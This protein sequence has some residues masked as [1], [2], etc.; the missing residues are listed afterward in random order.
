MISASKLNVRITF[1]I[2]LGM[3]ASSICWSIYN[4]YVPIILEQYVPNVTLL[5]VVMAV[6]NMFGVF[7]QPV[8]GIWS[9]RI[10]TRLGRRIPFII[11]GAP[12]AAVLFVVVPYS[13]S[14][15]GLMLT[16]ISFNVMMVTWRAPIVALMP[17]MTPSIHRS[18]ANGIINTMGGIGAVVAFLVGGILYNIGGMPMPFLVAS[19]GMSMC[20]LLMAIFVRERRIREQLGIRDTPVGEK[21]RLEKTQMSRE[22]LRSLVFIILAIF[23]CYFGFNSIETYFTLFA[24]KR[25]DISAGDA[26]MLMTIFPLA[27]FITAVPMG[28]LA[29]RIGRKRVLQLGIAVNFIA[30]I[31]A[32]FVTNMYL[33]GALLVLVGI[34]WGGIVV[35]ALPM[36]VEWGGETRAGLYT[37]IYYLFTGPAGML[38]PI[39]FGIVYDLTKSYDNIFLFCNAAF[40]IAFICL[41]FVRHGE[42]DMGATRNA[43]AGNV[44]PL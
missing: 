30:F 4:A 21:P 38:S 10:N 40:I 31:A 19:L 36:V 23:F 12:V 14:L 11:V 32:Y 1:L 18:K 34:F 9:D 37:S 29:T 27:F 41:L 28:I 43:E 44:Q 13:T 2:G 5:G 20:T 35:N 33:V 39:A 7:L 6:D 25:F 22:E 16:V 26:S 8:F 15:A 17:D 3:F 42:A 24:T